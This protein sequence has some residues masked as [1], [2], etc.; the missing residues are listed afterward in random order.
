MKP[1]MNWIAVAVAVGVVFLVVGLVINRLQPSA[2]SAPTSP[3]KSPF[4][5]G[6]RYRVLRSF[7][8]MRDAFSAGEILVF[9]SEGYSRYD[10]AA[11]YFFEA[12]D[13]PRTRAWDVRD[14][15]DL[16][17]WKTLFEEVSA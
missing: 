16:S 13:D 10:E 9:K 17:I 1:E 12:L 15:E 6:R 14:D 8:A 4:K 5:V 11:G 7:R 3:R 2:Y